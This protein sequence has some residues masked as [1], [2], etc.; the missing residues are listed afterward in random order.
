METVDHT[1][2]S[3]LLKWMEMVRHSADRTSSFTECHGQKRGRAQ[4][5]TSAGTPT[6]P[7]NIRQ[8][9]ELPSETFKVTLPLKCAIQVAEEGLYIDPKYAEFDKSV[10][11]LSFVVD[12]AF[13]RLYDSV[14]LAINDGES[15]IYIKDLHRSFDS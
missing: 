8:E 4:T 11:S 9:A 7:S 1:D 15:L 6:M 2:R 14:K 3:E 5:Q 13:V 10:T 12:C